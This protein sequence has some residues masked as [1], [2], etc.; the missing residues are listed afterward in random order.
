MFGAT[1]SSNQSTTSN[2]NNPTITDTFPTAE[3]LHQVHV[4]EFVTLDI[5]R[6]DPSLAIGF[7]F[8]NRAEF[9]AFCEETK[10]SA[11]RKLKEGKHPLYTVQ[12]LAPTFMYSGEGEEEERESFCSHS[13]DEEGTAE[14]EEEG[15][16]DPDTTDYSQLNESGRME[17]DA[18]GDT[19]L[20]A[21]VPAVANANKSTRA[22]KKKSDSKRRSSGMHGSSSSRRHSS[23]RAHRSGALPDPG[24]LPDDPD[25]EEYV[26]V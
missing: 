7:Y 10:L 6:L 26:L 18:S 14:E 25:D 17:V 4:S 16:D 2:N 21:P 3:Y 5:H 20:F 12:D 9:D 22:E 13:E 24:L 23:R 8:P 11:A 1:F 15:V 19:I